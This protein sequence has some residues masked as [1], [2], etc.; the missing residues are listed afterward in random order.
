MG[1]GPSDSINQ[2]DITNVDFDPTDARV[3]DPNGELSFVGAFDPRTITIPNTE[4]EEEV[5]LIDL[6][7]NVPPV[8]ITRDLL[9]DGHVLLGTANGSGQKLQ[10]IDGEKCLLMVYDRYINA[11][12]SLAG[13]ELSLAATG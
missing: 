9:L 8:I 7:G 2:F 12:N 1:N 13:V 3:N 5:I 4:I 6:E 11:F 10:V